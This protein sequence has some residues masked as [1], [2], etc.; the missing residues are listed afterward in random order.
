MH[1]RRATLPILALACLGARC[2]P[3][4][5]GPDSGET[6]RPPDFEAAAGLEARVHDTI[7]SLVELEWEQLEACSGVVAYRVEDE[8]WRS[9]PGRSFAPGA[10]AQLLLGVPYASRVQ[11]R[12]ELDCERGS[13]RSER[14]EIQ[15]DPLPDGLPHAGLISAVEGAWDP[16][17]SYILTS[18]DSREDAIRPQDA[19]TVIVDRAGR[20][21]W[22]RPTEIL[23]TTLAP[24][25]ALDGASLLID[26]NSFWGIFD[27][28]EAS[29]VV[30]VDLEGREIER[31][32]TPGLHH[33]FTELPDGTLAWGAADGM[34]ET[35][36]L[37][38]PGGEPRSLWSCYG[39]HQRVG[40]MLPCSANTLVW[41]EPRAS[42]LMSFFTTDSVV[43][44]DREGGSLRWFG[45]LPGSWAFEPVDSAF[46]WQHGA[47]FTAEGTLLTSTLDGEPGQEMLVREYD[48]D[49]EQQ[50]LRQRWSFGQGEGLY[51]DE[52]GE[53]WRLPGGHT[54][55]N[56]GTAQRLREITPDGEV[57]WDLG[58]SRGSFIGRSE[59]I[60]DL[61]DLLD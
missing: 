61:Y 58:W 57:V 24:R 4:D 8:D 10:A 35:L 16:S 55:H 13:W 2:A 7:G 44:I 28:G 51:G 56:M 15:T 6:G 60:E 26:H 59:G 3:R 46:Y 37:L 38:E 32:D 52:M 19:W 41:S 40:S 20:T 53:A 49:E 21:V 1:L 39:F 27:G 43:E 50:T 9:S 34:T 12:L 18:I 33:P 31:F 22:A 54:L 42:F 47:H 14:I 23:R 36:E 48:L 11:L 30:R 25:V 29:Q 5:P 45:H 17:W